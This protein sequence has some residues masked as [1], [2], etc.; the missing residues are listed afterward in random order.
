MALGQDAREFL[1][2]RQPLQ[3][4][5]SFEIEGRQVTRVFVSSQTGAGLPALRQELARI[6]AERHP[7]PE[8]A[9]AET[10]A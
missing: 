9:P 7:L 1:P 10:S 6:L 4:V 3:P 8:P 2:E 5:D